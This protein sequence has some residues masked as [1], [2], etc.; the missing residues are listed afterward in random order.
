M[1]V[2]TLFIRVCLA[3]GLA[4]VFSACTVAEVKPGQT[5]DAQ[6][7]TRTLTIPVG[8][9]SP[10]L[11]VTAP[12]TA[13]QVA[14]I[15][16]MPPTRLNPSPAPSL[17]PA[18]SQGSCS[19]QGVNLHIPDRDEDDNAP[20]EGWCG[21]TCI[22]MALEYY[23]KR[24]SQKA[25]NKAG[26]PAQPDLWEDDVPVALDALGVKYNLWDADNPDLE[27]FIAWVK[28]QL[29]A[30]YPAVVG[31]KIYPDEQPDWYVDHFVLAVGCG[32]QGLLV[33]TNNA[34]EGQV[35][36]PYEYLAATS[37]DI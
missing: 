27:A 21:E 8:K 30:G 25:I 19:G 10:L 2:S 16:G 36:V 35:W 28:S 15:A 23:G 9:N 22:Q 11:A 32:S 24:V 13:S 7:L 20:D 5:L 18:A 4:G 17:T 26:H 3:F 6:I 1:K 31:V 34:G 12:P 14:A 33:N 37:G 29:E